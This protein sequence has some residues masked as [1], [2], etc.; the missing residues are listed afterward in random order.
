MGPE[1]SSGSCKRDWAAAATGIAILLHA[2]AASLLLWADESKVYFLGRPLGWVCGLKSALGL[3]CP[4]CGMTRS[5][6]LSLHGEF[7]RAWRM[8]PAGP[9]VLLGLLGFAVALLAISGI[10]VAGATERDGVVRI[11]LRR[12]ALAYAGV[13]TTVWLGGWGASFAAA[14]RAR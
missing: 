10:R 11:W 13:A 14:W 12:C 1:P 3:P 6:V 8:A 7:A 9:V 2:M 4:T 5:I